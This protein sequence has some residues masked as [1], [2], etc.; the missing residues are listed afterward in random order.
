MLSPR[1]GGEGVGHGVDVLI[2]SG[3]KESNSPPPGQHN[4]LAKSIKSRHPEASKGGEKKY[5][6]DLAAHNK[7]AINYWLITKPSSLAKMVVISSKFL[8]LGIS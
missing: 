4:K 6:S 1:G 8:T 7:S 2:F 5:P 3:K